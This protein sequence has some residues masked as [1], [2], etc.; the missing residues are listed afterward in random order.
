MISEVKGSLM[1]CENRTHCDSAVQECALVPCAPQLKEGLL[2]SPAYMLLMV[3]RQFSHLLG[4]FVRWICAVFL[5]AV[6]KSDNEAQR[7]I[8]IQ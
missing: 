1:R 8:Y 4:H 6:M 3:C 7:V 2:I 5:C